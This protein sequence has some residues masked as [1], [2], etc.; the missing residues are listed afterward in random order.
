MSDIGTE[1]TRFSSY[2]VAFQLSSRQI[3]KTR[4]LF[5]PTN[6]NNKH[7][8]DRQQQR[9]WT[10]NELKERSL[11]RIDDT[12]QQHETTQE[13]ESFD[14]HI[15]RLYDRLREPSDNSAQASLDDFYHCAVTEQAPP[16]PR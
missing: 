1:I 11:G 13:E 16:T 9:S 5:Y 14:K 12:G 8:N 3:N 6:F 7:E 4:L 2:D 15:Y 10:T